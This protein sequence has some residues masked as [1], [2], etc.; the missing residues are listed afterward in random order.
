MAHFCPAYLYE[1]VAALHNPFDFRLR[2][3]KLGLWPHIS[4][5]IR[6]RSL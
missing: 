6:E 3:R 5:L 4:I 2:P 1:V